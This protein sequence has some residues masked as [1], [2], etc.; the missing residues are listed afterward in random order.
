MVGIAAVNN[1]RRAV[2]PLL[3]A[4]DRNLLRLAV[5]QETGSSTVPAKLAQ[6]AAESLP[7][8]SVSVP[9]ELPSFAISQYWHPR[10][11]TDAAVQSLRERIAERFAESPATRG[12]ARRPPGGPR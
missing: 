7:V 12:R 8:Q 1:Q 2:T 5:A 9:V 10:A 3:E 6:A 11:R 4:L